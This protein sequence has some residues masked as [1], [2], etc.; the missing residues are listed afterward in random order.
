MLKNIFGESTF[1]EKKEK[2]ETKKAKNWLKTISAFANEKGGILI[3][4]INDNDEVVGLSDYKKDSEFISEKIKSQIEPIPNIKIENKLEK[5]KILI[6]VT[7]EEG[8]Q[9]PY[10]YS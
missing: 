10:Y 2:V 3:F 4:G 9:T 5:G 6:F 7:V 8:N 1:Y